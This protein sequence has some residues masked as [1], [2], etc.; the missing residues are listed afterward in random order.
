M[1][2]SKLLRAS[3]ER[4]LETIAND[5]FA[6]ELQRF[7]KQSSFRSWVRK[8]HG[9]LGV[10]VTGSPN[11]LTVEGSIGRDVWLLALAHC[12]AI[13]SRMESFENRH[14]ISEDPG[15]RLEEAKRRLDALMKESGHKIKDLDDALERAIRNGRR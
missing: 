2:A 10:V 14:Y 6:H 1:E 15:E 4:Y 13:E 8:E 5:Q 11:R 12:H 7:D 3:R 9:E